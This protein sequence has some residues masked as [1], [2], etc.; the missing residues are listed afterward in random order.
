MGRGQYGLHVGQLTEPALTPAM[1]A[2]VHQAY[3]RG[4]QNLEAQLAPPPSPL[5]NVTH[6]APPADPWS[7]TQP[8]QKQPWTEE[9]KKDFSRTL[10]LASIGSVA[11]VILAKDHR[12]WG[13]I[14]GGMAGGG[15]ARVIFAPTAPDGAIIP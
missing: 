12:F 13:F 14:L 2:Q 4:K 7:V 5:N 11:G 8:P 1:Q 15:L 9:Q 6:L 3:E 10:G